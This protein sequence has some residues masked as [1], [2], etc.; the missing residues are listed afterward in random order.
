MNTV[1]SLEEAM[2]ES[3]CIIICSE[4]QRQTKHLMEKFH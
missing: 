2:N 3:P 4:I 1:F